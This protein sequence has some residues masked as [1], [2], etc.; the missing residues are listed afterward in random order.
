MFTTHLKHCLFF[1]SNIKSDNV[2]LREFC[3]SS[4]GLFEL[5][6]RSLKLFGI[7][8]NVIYSP[9]QKSSTK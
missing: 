3:L 8:A 5:V 1:L 4:H 6:C 2:V 9:I 7:G